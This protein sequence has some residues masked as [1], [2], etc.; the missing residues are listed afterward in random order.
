MNKKHFM[1]PKIDSAQLGLFVF[2]F[3]APLPYQPLD[4]IA[5]YVYPCFMTDNEDNMIYYPVLRANT[6]TNSLDKN[7]HQITDIRH[8][9]SVV[10]NAGYYVKPTLISTHAFEYSGLWKVYLFCFSI[11]QYEIQSNWLYHFAMINL[12]ETAQRKLVWREIF[13]QQYYAELQWV[14]TVFI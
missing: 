2:E 4:L 12:C 13:L 3:R 6:S 10:S 14:S 7:I 11:P 8:F 5:F 1:Y 9:I